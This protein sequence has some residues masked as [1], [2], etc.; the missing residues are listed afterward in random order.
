M[1][2]F[3]DNEYSVLIGNLLNDTQYVNISNMGKMAGLRKHAEVL[4]R[5]ILNLGSDIYLTLGQ[6]KQN[7]KN[8]YIYG[9]LK[10]LEGDLC[11][12]LVDVIEI[13]NRPG[14]DS[15]HTQHTEDFSDKEVENVEDALFDLYAIIFIKFFLKYGVS[16]YTSSLILH[17]FS[18]LP[19]IIRY[20]TWH[21]LYLKDKHNI[22][23]VNKL[24]L[25]I[26]KVYDKE[27]AYSW[28]EK[29]AEAIRAIPYPN[30]REQQKYL[31]SVGIPVAPGIVQV[32]LGFDRFDNMYDLLYD[33][34]KSN[35]T[36][37]NE[38]GKMYKN[39]EEVVNYYR[40]YESMGIWESSNEFKEFKSLMK[41]V[42]LGRKSTCE[43]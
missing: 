30:E 32:S 1:R 24:C 16:I 11:T 36:S 42:Y 41:F 40:S 17:E 39:F 34:I 22:Q 23:V 13:I 25:S 15:T 27:T 21:F 3:D 29:N 18:I 6:V 19:P 37:V 2:H 35:N 38:S 31:Y 9:A 12:K 5:K 28:I 26:I 14:C 7:T 43:L 4:V 20:K 33:K 8:R 10:D